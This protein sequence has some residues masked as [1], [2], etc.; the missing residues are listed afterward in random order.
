M[1]TVVYMKRALLQAQQR[2]PQNGALDLYTS[3]IRKNIRGADNL[4]KTVNALLLP[5]IETFLLNFSYKHSS[6]ENST[7]RLN[8]CIINTV[9]V[10][11]ISSTFPALVEDVA[12]YG[13]AICIFQETEA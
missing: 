5:E 9:V 3:R 6:Q 13:Y 8:I 1:Y 7:C 11:I 12:T 4:P 10:D 2:A